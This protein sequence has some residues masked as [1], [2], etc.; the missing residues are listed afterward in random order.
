MKKITLL[1]AILGLAWGVKAQKKGSINEIL[2]KSETTYGLNFST[3]AGLIGGVTI[4]HTRAITPKMYHYFGLDAVNIRH[5]KE[6]RS[7]S[8]L[9]GQ[10]FIPG[11]Q[12]A[13]FMLRP[14]YGREFILFKKEAEQGV[15]INTHF[16]AGPALGLVVPYF[17]EYRYDNRSQRTEQYDPAKHILFENV[18]GS[19]GIFSGLGQSSLTF[20]G[21]VRAGINFEFGSF[22]NNVTGFELGIAA[23]FLS[24]KVILMPL[25]EN[26]SNFFSAYVVLFYGGRK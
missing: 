16:S 14:T 9:S 18:V 23:D 12:N 19:P 6:Q 15:Q 3:N 5:P 7:T 13:L 10:T 26:R 4:R 17:I 20:G 25:A 8:R 21:T 2:Y 11:K 24:N 1:F 22:K